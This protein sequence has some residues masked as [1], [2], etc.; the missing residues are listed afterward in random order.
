MNIEQFIRKYEPIR[1]NGEIV[2]YDLT[3]E[4]EWNEIV[5]AHKEKKV[6]TVVENEGVMILL[7][8]IHYANRIF[9]IITKHALEE[10]INFEY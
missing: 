1:S 7:S 10:E 2:Q 9:Y 5:K 6:C 4:H 3:T 8:G